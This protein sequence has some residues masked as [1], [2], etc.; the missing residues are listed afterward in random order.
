MNKRWIHSSLILALALGIGASVVHSQAPTHPKSAKTKAAK[1]RGD[2]NAKD[3]NIKQDRA[4]ND[5][6]AKI[7]APPEKGGSKTRGGYCRVHI[8]NWTPYRID[9]YIDGDYRGEVSRWGDSYGWVGCGDTKFYG[10]AT[11]TDGSVQIWGPSVY[12]VD[13][14][15][16]WTLTP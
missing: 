10:R 7:E 8:N 5:P 3:E 16:E 11:F 9:I 14:T 13:G 1:N 15:F 2:S 12:Y 4:P 6:N